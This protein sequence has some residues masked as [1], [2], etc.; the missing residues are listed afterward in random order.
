MR[1]TDGPK[2]RL[3]WPVEAW[4]AWVA[5]RKELTATAPPG[6]EW[7][8]D[9]GVKL[10]VRCLTEPPL[11]PVS[12]ADLSEVI[13]WLCDERPALVDSDPDV[14]T[15]LARC[16]MHQNATQEEVRGFAKRIGGLGSHGR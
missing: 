3:G 13:S 15:R 11:R 8:G 9:A 6:V 1:L 12:E 5:E 14:L 7:P 4:E 16:L 2:G 10:S